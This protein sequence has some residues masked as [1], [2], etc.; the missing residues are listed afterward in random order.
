[1]DIP[2]QLQRC[3]AL[4]SIMLNILGEADGEEGVQKAHELMSRAYAVSSSH[5]SLSASSP[6]SSVL[7]SMTAGAD[8]LGLLGVSHAHSLASQCTAEGGAL[9]AAG[10]RI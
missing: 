10:S 8:I 4:C 7:P 2:G 3:V 9:Y 5:V 6:Q 1:M